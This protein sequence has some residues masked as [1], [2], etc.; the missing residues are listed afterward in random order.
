MPVLIDAIG[1]IIA[2][3][4]RLWQRSAWDLTRSR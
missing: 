3:H 2:G 1:E 4:A